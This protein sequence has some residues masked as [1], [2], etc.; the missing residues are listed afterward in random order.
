MLKD[1]LKLIKEEYT[2]HL[3]AHIKSDAVEDDIVTAGYI[4]KVACGAATI[5]VPEDLEAV[6][7]YVIDNT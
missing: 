4:F 6:E 5:T 1:E 7:E 3:K 2:F